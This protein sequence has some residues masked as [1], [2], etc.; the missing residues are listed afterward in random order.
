MTRHPATTTPT[1]PRRA[2]RL[3]AA[4]TVG[5]TALVPLALPSAAGAQTDGGA[6]TTP[7]TSARCRPAPVAKERAAA[8]IQRRQATIAD[9]LASL[10]GAPDPYG[11]NGAQIDALNAAATGL[12]QLGQQ[13]AT[14]C[15]PDA[16]SFK[17]DA[18]RIFVDYRI[19]AL[20]VPQTKAIEA[21]DHLGGARGRLQQVADGLGSVVGTNTKTRAELDAMNQSL[22][23]AD[24]TLGHP[25]TLQGAMAAVPGLQPAKD[26]SPIKAALTAAR[27]DLQSTRQDLAAARRHAVAALVALGG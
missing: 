21:A 25:P 2:R 18:S 6:T 7:P 1:H 12:T 15:Y 17:A 13:I 22:A 8:E 10:H 5:L 24:A 4:T 27:S 11:L 14:T 23:A 16:A 20:R 26:L 3:L 9:L 19:Y